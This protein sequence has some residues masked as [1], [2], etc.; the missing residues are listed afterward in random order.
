MKRG[1]RSLLVLGVLAVVI[2]GCGSSSNSS[3]GSS[4]SGSSGQTSSSSQS[5]ASAPA[6]MKLMFNNTSEPAIEAAIKDFKS[7]EPKTTINAQYVDGAAVAQALL[8]QLRAGSPPDMFQT[9]PTTPTD[10]VTL[11]KAGEVLDLAGQPWVDGVAPVAKPWIT[12]GTKVYGLPLLYDPD[13]MAYNTTLFKQ[14]HLQIPTTFAQLLAMCPKITAAGK[15]PITNGFAGSLVTGIVIG[16]V[17]SSEF[18]YNKDPN[19]DAEKASGKV[20]FANSP[21]WRAA[22]NSVVS[23][24]NAGCFGKSPEGL[25]LTDEAQ[26]FASGQAAMSILA[27]PQVA[28]AQ[29]INP[30]LTFAFFNFP[31]INASD[32]V[33]SAAISQVLSVSSKTAHPTQAKAFLD[34]L[35]TGKG[36]SDLAK[37][38]LAG[39]SAGGLKG[40]GLPSFAEPMSPALKA[41]KLVMTVHAYPNP[42]MLVGQSGIA[43]GITGLIT[44]Q[45]S[46]SQVL[47]NLDYLWAHPTATTAP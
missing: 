29:Q 4:T 37:A 47:K 16:E 5:A 14:L 31:A 32:T 17:V 39:L 34:F 1:W 15:T 25:T 19:W 10:P 38:G 40:Q 22:L 9:Q 6:T 41:G 42:T 3:S 33:A 7:V 24:K 43:G 21:L 11:G 12:S 28:G 36:A 46:V 44:G 18:V 20:T 23:M 13:G 35:A 45:D 27:W 8:P 30:K 26:Q 2:A